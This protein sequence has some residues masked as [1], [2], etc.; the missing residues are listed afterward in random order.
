MQ[1]LYS[2]LLGLIRDTGA[3]RRRGRKMFWIGLPLK[4]EW[5]PLDF[6]SPIKC[7]FHS[8]TLWWLHYR[9]FPWRPKPR[10]TRRRGKWHC[11]EWFV[12]ISET[13]AD[14]DPP[15]ETARFVLWWVLLGLIPARECRTAI[16]VSGSPQYSGKQSRPWRLT[17]SGVGNTILLVQKESQALVAYV[18]KPSYM[19]N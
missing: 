18:S 11:L 8:T 19:G 15:Y 4:I 14:E 16:N 2:W 12:V 9:G 10:A 3:G 17:K 7:A 5:N 1:E 13:S 6:F